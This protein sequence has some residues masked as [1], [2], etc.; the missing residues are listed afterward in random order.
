MGNKKT[1]RTKNKKFC[2][3]LGWMSNV[4]KKNEK[5]GKEHGYSTFFGFWFNIQLLSIC[6][7]K[8]GTLSIP[9]EK[10]Q[11]GNVLMC[12]SAGPNIK[13]YRPLTVKV[14]ISQSFGWVA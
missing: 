14:W 7:F 5:E 6:V 12:R 4:N 3:L 11:Y 13:F 2:Y 8:F 1:E 10:L 9:M